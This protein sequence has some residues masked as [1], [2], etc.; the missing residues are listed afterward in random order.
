MRPIKWWLKSVIDDEWKE[1]TQ[2]K[3]VAVERLAGFRPKP[4]LGPEATGGFSDGGW[5]GKLEYG[6]FPE[7]TES[8]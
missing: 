6:E 1:V 8:E 3:W 5:S 7:K 4:G 2:D